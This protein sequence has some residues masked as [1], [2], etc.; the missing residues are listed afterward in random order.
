MHTLRIQTREDGL[1]IDQIILSPTTFLHSSPGQPL[2]D[3]SVYPEQNGGGEGSNVPP[4][5]ALTSPAHGATF[6]VPVT[7]TVG[8]DA[9]DADGA[10]VRVD[11]FANGTSI[12]T[13]ATAPYSIEW[14]ASSANTYSLTAVAVDNEGAVSAS[15]ARTVVVTAGSSGAGEEIVIWAHTA[16][17]APGW[18]VV[19]DG[20]AAGGYRL[21]DPNLRAPKVRV[22][23]E[24]PAR[25]VELAFD[26][27]A[28]RPYRLWLRSKAIGNSYE[29]DSVWVQFSGSVTAGG[30][31]AYRIGTSSAT[32]VILE[33]GTNAAMAGWGWS[34]NGYG[35][36]IVGPAIYFAVDGRQTMRIQ[37]REDGLGIDQIVLSAGHYLHSSPGTTTA[38]DTVLAPTP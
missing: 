10:I 29:N 19:A 15:V 35:T 21:Q 11:F 24:D 32:A 22:P 18:S 25:Y 23:R 9:T 7:M 33:E 17:I 34:D 27:L 28:G 37:T 36:G 26:A 5:V 4:A 31:P 12:G 38:D 20:T 8:A 6:T 13:D 1:S 2:A 30:A 14:T 3:S 16:P